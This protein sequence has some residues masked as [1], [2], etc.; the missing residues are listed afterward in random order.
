MRCSAL[1]SVVPNSVRALTNVSDKTGPSLES[2]GYTQ[3]YSYLQ[4]IIP[5]T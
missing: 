4:A 3:Y 5:T 1:A 2:L